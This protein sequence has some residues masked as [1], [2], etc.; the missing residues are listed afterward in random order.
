[1]GGENRFIFP[2]PPNFP[3]LSPLL[4]RH[5]NTD[6]VV[7]LSSYPTTLHCCGS[8]DFLSPSGINAL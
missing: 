5:R 8:T 3:S 4:E 1:M 2:F 6:A 7:S